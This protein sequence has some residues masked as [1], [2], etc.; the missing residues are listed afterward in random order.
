GIVAEIAVKEGDRVVTGQVLVRLDE[1]DLRA[2]LSIVESMLDELNATRARLLAERDDRA[3]IEFPGELSSRMEDKRIADILTGQRK[4]FVIQKA[5][6]RGRIEQ[7]TERIGQLAQEVTG[8]GAQYDSKKEQTRLVRE[9]LD[10]LRYLLKRGLMQA[11][12]V[13]AL[14]RERA[15]LE[16]Q[17]GELIAQIAGT[18]GRISEIRLQMIQLDDDARTKTLSDLRETE[19]GIAEA[20]QRRIA[21]HAKLERAVIRAPRPGYVH[22]LAVHTIGGVIASGADIMAIVPDLDQ[23]VIDVHVRPE[24]IDQVSVGQTAQLRFPAFDQ[25]TTPEVTG[26]VMQVA[27]D[28]TKPTD[29]QLPYYAVRI[30]LAATQVELLGSNTLKPGMPAEAFIRTRER[31]PFSYLLQPLTD[32]IAHTFREG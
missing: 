6:L 1:T 21:A 11:N 9:E 14:D 28:L 26:E 22:Q 30:R 8:L 7:L 19:A 31:T 5:A 12:R 15:N 24:D 32:Q 16:G 18:K 25:R 17:E 27:A 2:E 13:F 20:E 4:L 29:Q 23:L 10:N 3:E